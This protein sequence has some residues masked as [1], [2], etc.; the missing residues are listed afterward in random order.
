[1]ARPAPECGSRTRWVADWDLTRET[2]ER[3]LFSGKDRI[4]T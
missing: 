4:G 2:A 3:L 1:M